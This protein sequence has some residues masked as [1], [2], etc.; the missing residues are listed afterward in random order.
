[1]IQVLGHNDVIIFISIFIP[2][3]LART[4]GFR[5]E[6]QAPPEAREKNKKVRKAGEKFA[7][8]MHPKEINE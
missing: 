7:E 8:E 4:F 2:K 6:V 5:I 3:F 1:M